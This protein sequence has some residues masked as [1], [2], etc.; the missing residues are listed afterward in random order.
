MV[1]IITQTTLNFCKT[2]EDNE[3]R[4]H[5]C[6]YSFRKI[7]NQVFCSIL[8]NPYGTP[9]KHVE[10]AISDQADSEVSSGAQVI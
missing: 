7:V 4:S 10:C 1:S 6:L 2:F 5:A 8:L 3:M 9:T